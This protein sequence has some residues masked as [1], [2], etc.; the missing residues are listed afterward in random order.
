[1]K[2]YIRDFVIFTAGVIF[3]ILVLDAFGV[4]I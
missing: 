4:I 1:M 3:G 2:D